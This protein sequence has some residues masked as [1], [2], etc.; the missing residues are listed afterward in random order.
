MDKVVKILLIDDDKDI[1]KI[2]GGVLKKAGYKVDFTSDGR[3]ALA[4]ASEGDY[5]LILL[6]VMIPEIDG[7]AL[8]SELKKEP[9][10][11]ENGPIILLTNIAKPEII[12][13][14]LSLGAKASLIK[15]DFSPIQISEKVKKYL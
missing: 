1:R 11:K 2:Y 4:K 13:K 7:L 14:G 15:S 9:P 3:E 5:S 12:R 10:K 8:L 6:D